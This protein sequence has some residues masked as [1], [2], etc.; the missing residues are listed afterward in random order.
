MDFIFI[1]VG[2]N[3]LLIFLYKREWLFETKPFCILLGINLILFIL[4]YALINNF[5][6]DPKFVAA[7]K[8]P[9]ISQL[10]F[11]VMGW[12]FYTIY[13]RNPVDTFWSMDKK[14]MKDGLFNFCFWVLGGFLPAIWML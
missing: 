4:G 5:I 14:L 10:I 3:I 6:G 8:M 1:L 7:L 2:I 11:K 9:L 13:N 12:C